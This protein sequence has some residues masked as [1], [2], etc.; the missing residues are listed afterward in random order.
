MVHTVVS[1]NEIP[2]RLTAER[3]AH[4]VEEHNELAGLRLDVL[5]TVADPERILAGG[6]GEFFGL[7]GA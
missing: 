2:V 3:W 7:K 4:I 1:K 5:E 6:A